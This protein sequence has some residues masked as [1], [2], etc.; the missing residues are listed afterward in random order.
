MKFFQK[1]EKTQ[2]TNIKNEK[3]DIAT[4]L[5]NFKELTKP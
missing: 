5:T 2:I 4:D 3:V 1:R